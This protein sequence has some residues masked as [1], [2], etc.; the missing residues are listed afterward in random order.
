MVC[1]L[2]ALPLTNCSLLDEGTA[3]AEAMTMMFGLRSKEQVKEG[4]DTIF[5]DE[6]TQ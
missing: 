1:D 5:V 2:T 3:A 4:I 6:N